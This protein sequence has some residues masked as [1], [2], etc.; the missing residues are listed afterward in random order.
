MQK[1]IIAVVVIISA[2]FITAGAVFFHDPAP[3]TAASVA[4]DGYRKVSSGGV[5]FEWKVD[6]KHLRVKLRAKTKGWV[7]AGFNP[8][9][10]MK[11]AD[12][13]IGYVKNGRAVIHD[14]YGNGFFSHR[15]DTELGGKDN[16]AE[17]AGSEKGGVTG[18]SF[19]IPLNSGDKHDAVL[20]PGQSLKLLLAHGSDNADNVTS[21][22]AARGSV[23]IKL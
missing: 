9:T 20:K 16:I 23:T 7:A 8:K 14:E 1:R 11:G 17:A 12:F 2:G 13:I 15:P 10:K 4:G 3:V 22:H 5:D 6:G 18:L 19:K 21:K